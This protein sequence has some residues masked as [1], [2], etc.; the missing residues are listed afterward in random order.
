MCLNVVYMG[1]HVCVHAC[2]C[3]T[4][5]ASF[6]WPTVI[7]FSAANVYHLHCRHISGK[8]SNG[9]PVERFRVSQM[10]AGTPVPIGP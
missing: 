6:N 8:G 4:F 1:V 7:G 3:L 5:L 9:S 2:V 10:C